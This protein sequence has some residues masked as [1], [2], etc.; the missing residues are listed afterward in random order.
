MAI[1]YYDEERQRGDVTMTECPKCERPIPD[2]Q[3]FSE[4]WRYNCP[5]NPLNADEAE[6]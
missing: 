4:H 3:G 5:E 2:G 1:H 6:A